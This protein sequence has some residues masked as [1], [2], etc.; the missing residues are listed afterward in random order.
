ML[1]RRYKG[2]NTKAQRRK[3]TKKTKKARLNSPLPFFEP[4]RLCVNE[5]HTSPAFFAQPNASPKVVRKATRRRWT[6]CHADKR[7]V[8]HNPSPGARCARELSWV[9]RRTQNCRSLTT[10]PSARHRVERQG[11]AEVL[12]CS[13][14]RP[15]AACKMLRARRKAGGRKRG[16]FFLPRPLAGKCFCNF[17]RAPSQVPPHCMFPRRCKGINTKAQKR[18]SA[19]K[20]K[21]ARFNSPTCSSLS[22]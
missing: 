15:A 17:F 22:L 12:H 9:A 11:F 21:K 19:K 6:R 5:T 8:S 14:F 13:R 18:K 10:R 20:T 3:G 16:A 2:I 4:S 1:L 7:L